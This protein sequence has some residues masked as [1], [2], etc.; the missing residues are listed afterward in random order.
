MPQHETGTREEWL[1][2]RL[3]LLDAEKEHTR[4]GDE[5]ARRRREL[6][7][8]AIDKDYRFET[9]EGPASL[10]D[11]FRGPLAA[12]DVPLHVR[13]RLHRRLPG[14]L[15]DR[16][17]LQRLA[18]PPREPRRAD[19]GRLARSDRRDPNVQVAHGVDVPMGL[20]SRRRL[21][22]RLQRLGD[23]GTAAR[24]TGRLQLRQSGPAAGRRRHRRR[25][26]RAARRGAGRTRRRIS[27][28][29]RA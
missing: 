3:E 1:A 10:A 21:Q 6:P 13:A 4:R 7:W 15:C 22:L 25:P 17:R 18:R 5:L 28:R 26:G 27:A 8:V 24:R 23:R 2:K 29:R 20:V 9:D 14:V 12:P 11:L 16:G 19:D